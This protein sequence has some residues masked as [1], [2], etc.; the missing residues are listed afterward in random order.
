MHR[1][2]PLSSTRSSNDLTS[3]LAE[4]KLA[5]AEFHQRLEEVQAEAQ[6]S[7]AE[8]EAQLRRLRQAMHFE[9]LE[10]MQAATHCRQSVQELASIHRAM[11][12]CMQRMDALEG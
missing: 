6:G 2:P 10:G 5:A 1:P 3:E 11:D 9:G 8:S 7:A 4:A 12:A